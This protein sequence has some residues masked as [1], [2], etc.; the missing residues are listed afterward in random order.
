VLHRFGRASVASCR[1]TDPRPD[2]PVSL[3]GLLG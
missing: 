2:Q 1:C 3:E